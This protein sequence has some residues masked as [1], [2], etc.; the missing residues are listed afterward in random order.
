MTEQ[1]K[2]KHDVIAVSFQEDSAAF[3]ALSSR[4]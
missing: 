3:Q 2:G 1:P 4:R